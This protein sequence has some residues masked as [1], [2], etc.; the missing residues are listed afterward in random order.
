M[1]IFNGIQ[2]ILQSSQSYMETKKWIK[3]AREPKLAKVSIRI[4]LSE[5]L[6]VSFL[7]FK[8]QLRPTLNFLMSFRIDQSNKE[9]NFTHLKIYKI[10]AGFALGYSSVIMCD[11][12]SEKD[13]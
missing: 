10:L 8:A 5:S 11:T 7:I 3:P 12:R 6:K 4:F 9:M 13:L 2:Q 1:N